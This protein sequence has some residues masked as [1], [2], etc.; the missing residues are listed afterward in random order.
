MPSNNQITAYYNGLYADK[1]NKFSEKQMQLARQSMVGYVKQLQRCGSFNEHATFL[2]LGG[3]LGYYAQAAKEQGMHSTLVDLDKCSVDFAT[4][5]HNLDAVCLG[6]SEE[7][8]AKSERKYDIVFLRHVI[9]HY[10]DP[11]TLL[12][13][14]CTLLAEGGVL[15]LE[16]D[17]NRGI[18]M[19]VRP[20]T[21]KWYTDLYKGRF[22]DVSRL[23]LLLKRPFAVDPPRHLHGFSIKNLERMMAPLDMKS[24]IT[25]TYRLGDPI[26]WPNLPD[27]SIQEVARPFIRLNLRGFVDNAVDF[28]LLPLRF[29]LAAS[30]HA[31]GLCIYATKRK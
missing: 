17:N 6:T 29:I 19:L 7:F 22:K 25:H 31:A 16:T 4:Q 18:E 23:S 24:L 13:A 15:I 27:T 11:R 26:Y 14:A 2:D 20:G 5:H 21:R 28:C 30:G 9:E 3:G 8:A 12:N 1:A 10:V